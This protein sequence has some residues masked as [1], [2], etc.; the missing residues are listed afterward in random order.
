M[1]I[2]LISYDDTSKREDLVDILSNVSPQETPL[3]SGLRKASGEG[4]LHEWLSDTYAASADNASVEASAFTVVD[5]V[6][7]TRDN[8]FMQIFYEAVQV[9][10]TE[11]SIKQGHAEDP[12]TYQI[13]KNMVEHGKDIERALVAG[14][15]ASGSS[16]VARR[17]SGLLNFVSANYTVRDSG[18]SLGETTFNDILEMIYNQTDSVAT[19]I[20]VGGTLKRDIS[21][22]TAGTTKFTD[23]EDKRLI[24]PVDIY[25][26]DFGPAKIFLHR[27]VGNGANAKALL[28]VNPEYLQ[29]AFLKGRQ[30][31]METLEKDGDRERAQIVSELTL[32]KLADRVHAV[33]K[34]FT[35]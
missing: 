8:N 34:G 26:S 20:Y 10:G 27:E 30:T 21:Q 13:A 2:G 19:E 33:V 24:R 28:A 29:I 31:K 6:Q 11:M 1:A 18:A 7:P 9:S 17:M 35:A 4:V 25:V 32:E 16:G 3:L 14:S 15:R 23:Q 12:M 22:F 5:H